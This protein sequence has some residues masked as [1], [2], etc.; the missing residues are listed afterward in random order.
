MTIKKTNFIYLLSFSAICT[1]SFFLMSY[2]TEG[3]QSK[4]IDAYREIFKL[5]INEAYFKYYSIVDSLEFGH[6]VITWVFSNLCIEKNILISIANGLLAISF[7]YYGKKLNASLLVLI[8]IIFLNF[9]FLAVYTELERLKFAF[10]FFILSLIHYDKKKLFY[11]FS[12]LSIFTHLQ[13][14]ILYAGFLFVFAIQQVKK[15]LI[16][17]KINWRFFIFIIFGL[18]VL[19]I[20]QEHLTRK[21][22]FYFQELDFFAFLKVL[23]LLLFTL[24]YSK[25]RNETALV[26]FVLSIAVLIVGGDRLNI[27]AY[28][29]FLYY[30]LQYE[31]GLNFGILITTLYFSVKAIFFIINIFEYGRGY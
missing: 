12:I 10:L 26:L 25:K 7:L 23:P 9:Y 17:Y 24:Y 13:F 16:T 18:A 30:G 11:L 8:P 4:Y 21:L 3:D 28:F 6:F 15:V 19:V 1:L 2:Y 27:F 31:R 14:L 5:S 29:V 20:M 22:R